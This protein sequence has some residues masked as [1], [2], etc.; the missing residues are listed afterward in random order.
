MKVIA[1]K[2]GRFRN[3]IYYEQSELDYECED[4]ITKFLIEK[5]GFVKYPIKTDD[6]TIIIEQRTSDFDMY[7]DLSNEGVDIEGVTYFRN[8]SKPSV[9]ISNSLSEQNR[10][11]RLRTTL[12]H[13]LGHVHFH[14]PLISI[15]FESPHLP[16]F[17]EPV[18]KI[19]NTISIKCN[20]DS[21][22]N[23]SQVDWVEW[24]AG[25]ASCAFLMPITPLRLL[26]QSIF[27]EMNYPSKLAYSSI[28]AIGII[29]QVQ[30]AFQVSEDASRVRLLKLGYLTEKLTPQSIF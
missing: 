23:A 4:I 30:E 28:E 25:Y 2:T 16:F 22:I 3:R 18:K 8:N 29:H 10:E 12:T 9:K 1:D 7:A 24:Q 26:I 15:D 14:L 11:N 17:D 19:S 13:E 5:Y 21:I 20:R 27:H 6:L